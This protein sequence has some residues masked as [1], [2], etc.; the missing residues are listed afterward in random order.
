MRKSLIA[1]VSA[2][3][4][5]SFVLIAPGQAGAVDTPITFGVEGGL[6]SIAAPT[7]TQTLTIS[8]QN[9]SGTINGVE[10]TDARRGIVG[11]A[12]SAV[13]SDLVRTGPPLATIPATAAT[14]TSSLPTVVSGIVT[15]L[16]P[17]LPTPPPYPLATPSNVMVA[18]VVLG[19]NVVRWNGTIN[20]ALPSNVT[21]GVYNGII[22][23]S[24]A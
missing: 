9:A 15:V 21:T 19:S 11:W 1:S 6:L 16:P 20:V 7:A 14:Y 12:A 17:I 24:V 4:A 8:G 10:V 2:A 5:L 13:S 18:T 23:H 22:T 3:S